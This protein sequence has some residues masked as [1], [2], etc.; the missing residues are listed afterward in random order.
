MKC[1]PSLTTIICTFG[2]TSALGRIT[3]AE[4]ELFTAAGMLIR[5]LRADIP[6]ATGYRRRYDSVHSPPRPTGDTGC[7]DQRNESGPPGGFNGTSRDQHEGYNGSSGC[8]IRSACPMV[9]LMTHAP[10][11]ALT[12]DETHRFRPDFDAEGWPSGRWRW[13]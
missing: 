1:P 9:T 7:G 3:V 10:E 11:S 4:G 8:A 13:S 12:L 2:D 5:L 6:T